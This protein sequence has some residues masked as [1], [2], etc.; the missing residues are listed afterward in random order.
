MGV[1]VCDA[2]FFQEAEVGVPAGLGKVVDV[3][4]YGL[5][6]VGGG[7]VED[8][9]CEGGV[10]PDVVVVDPPDGIFAAEALDQFTGDA[11]GEGGGDGGE[12]GVRGAGDGAGRGGR[13]GGRC[14]G[15]RVA[16]VGAFGWGHG[17]FGEAFSGDVPDGGHGFGAGRFG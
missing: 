4:D 14:G 12:L 2:R 9:F 10:F 3:E 7:D 1:E 13:C 15:S 6:G 8:G 5:L 16:A 11:A 17:V